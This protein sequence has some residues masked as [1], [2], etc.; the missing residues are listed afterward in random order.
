MHL[1]S[2]QRMKL[3]KKKIKILFFLFFIEKFTLK[4]FYKAKIKR[5]VFIF[6]LFLSNENDFIQRILLGNWS[7]SSIKTHKVGKSFHCIINFII[8]NYNFIRIEYSSKKKEKKRINK[9]F[10]LKRKLLLF[11]FL[12]IFV[13]CI[14][15]ENYFF[16]N[17]LKILQ[18]F[19]I[20]SGWI[21]GSS[22]TSRFWRINSN[23]L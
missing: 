19:D 1:K 21:F 7:C 8:I 23:I 5:K 10:F 22:I 16:L 9:T 3:P 15:L 17:K 20:L 18:P 6:W 11:L 14:D 13:W 4:I 2:T 12:E